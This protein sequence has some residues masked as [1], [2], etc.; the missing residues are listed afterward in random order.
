MKT[1]EHR[2]FDTTGDVESS[3]LMVRSGLE[4]SDALERA[5][6]IVNAVS[7]GLRELCAAGEGNNVEG[8]PVQVLWALAQSLQIAEGLIHSCTVIGPA[9]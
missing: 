5:S 9:E 2:F 7:G 1:S 4:A 3:L 8:Q 6:C